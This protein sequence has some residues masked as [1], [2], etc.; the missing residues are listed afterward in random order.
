MALTLADLLAPMDPARFFAEFHDRQPLHVKGAPGKFAGVLSWRGID[1][2]LDQSHVWSSHSL[3]LQMDAQAVPPEAYCV[4]ATSRDNAGVM[5]PHAE[6]VRE[7]VARGASVILNDVDSLTPGLAGVSGALE[8]AGLGRAQAN[9]YV[10]FQAHKAFPTHFDTHDVW[11]VQVEGEKTWN[12]W[13]GRADY[14]IAH[15]AFRSLGQA[16]HDRARG[17]LREKVTLRAGDLL[18]LPRGWYHDALAEGTTS[19]HVAYGTNAVL[20]IEFAQMLAERVMGDSLFRAPLP[21]QDGTPAAGFAL[22]QRAAHLGQKLAEYA[23]DPAVLAALAKHV[24]EARFP[25]GGN[26]L[27]AAR[28]LEP[29]RDTDDPVP[30]AEGEA[31]AFRVVA[32]DAKPV[33]RGAEWVLKTGAGATAL[34]PPEAEAAGWILARREVDPNALRAAHP[35]VD[36][37]ALLSRLARAGVL[38][39][40]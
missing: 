6:R 10:S 34:S 8:A 20:G 28:G 17:E 21:R 19:V 32:G 1:R 38:A 39:A 31:P 27:L 23:R 35:A 40:A 5:Q 33:R 24:A 22:T 26:H 7:W 4:R 14:P 12:I 3:K 9:V 16:H 18:Y 37:E 11:A 2:L 30:P 36:A 29:P 25:R 13:S 15:P